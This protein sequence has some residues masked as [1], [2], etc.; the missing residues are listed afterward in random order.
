M[1]VLKLV[2]VLPS[3]C[4]K[5]DVLN[6]FKQIQAA[7]HYK[8]NGIQST[9]LPYDLCQVEVEPVYQSFQGWDCSLDSAKKF[10]ELPILAQTYLQ[11][12]EAYLGVPIT[13]IST[14]PEREKLIVRSF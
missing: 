10:E 12:L 4:T 2:N 8:Y 1:V 5:I 11:F 14:G 13:L 7:T 6:S 3:N 9:E